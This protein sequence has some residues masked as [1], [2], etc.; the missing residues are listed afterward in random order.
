MN[1]EDEADDE[2]ANQYYFAGVRLVIPGQD[3]QEF[4]RE[5]GQEANDLE[6]RQSDE[7]RAY[8][9]G[10]QAKYTARREKQASHISALLED[11][12]ET[13]HRPVPL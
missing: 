4:F 6:P 10:L 5:E 2:K 13:V 8:R 12:L 1:L 9:Q 3:E 7:D 11:I